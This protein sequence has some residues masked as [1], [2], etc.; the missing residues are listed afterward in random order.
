MLIAFGIPNMVVC[1]ASGEA[2]GGNSAHPGR[3]RVA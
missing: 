2:F 3:N 1:L